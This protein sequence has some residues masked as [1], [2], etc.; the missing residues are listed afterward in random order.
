MAA[1]YEKLNTAA[2]D[3]WTVLQFTGAQVRTGYA[4]AVLETALAAAD[5]R[6]R[7]L[8]DALMA[9]D[10]CLKATDRGEA[11]AI[12]RALHFHGIRPS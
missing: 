8:V 1:D 6:A 5:D 7:R 9:G 2:L 12:I 11:E 4:L 3:G 10:S